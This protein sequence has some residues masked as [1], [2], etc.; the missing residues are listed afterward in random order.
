[1]SKEAT[2]EV[3]EAPEQVGQVFNTDDYN[4]MRQVIIAF[5]ERGKVKPEEM[6]VIGNVYNKLV[7]HLLSI[8]AL[9]PAEPAQ[10]DTND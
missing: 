1:M 9:T 10:G 5:T 3:I 6:M 8:G 7:A 4:V 2:P